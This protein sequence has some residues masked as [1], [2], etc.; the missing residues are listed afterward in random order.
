MSDFSRLYKENYD[1]VYNFCLK[2]YGRDE[3][4]PET[5]PEDFCAE[6]T[7]EAFYIAY[8]N[9]QQI[10]DETKFLTWVTRI[11]IHQAQKKARHDRLWYNE[12]PDEDIAMYPKVASRHP[13]FRLD[14]ESPVSLWLKTL[15]PGDRQLFVY[16]YLYLMPMKEISEET[17]KPLGTVK[18]RLAYLKAQ[19]KKV[20]AAASAADA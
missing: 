7:Q 20:L 6:I 3:F 18:R 9:Q 5:T 11:A 14:G 13:V 10:R 15:K 12:L 16:R 2:K 4:S 8:L 1:K 17:R 19:C